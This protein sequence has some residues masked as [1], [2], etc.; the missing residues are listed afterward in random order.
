M[1]RDDHRRSANALDFVY[2]AAMQNHRTF[3]AHHLLRPARRIAVAISAFYALALPFAAVSA[4]AGEANRPAVTQPTTPAA[5]AAASPKAGAPGGGTRAATGSTGANTARRVAASQSARESTLSYEQVMYQYLLS[6]IA[7]QRG[8]GALATRGMLDLAKRSNDPRIARRAAEIAFQS[9]QMSE[10]REAL[11]LWLGL[12]P[13]AGVAR[14]ALAALV[15][16]QA[17]LDKTIEALS[18]WLAEKSFQPVLFT[19]TP[20]LVARFPDRASAAAAVASLASR[21]PASAEAQ[22]AVAATAQLAG[23]STKALDAIERA[24][25]LAPGYA[26]AAMAKADILRSQPDGLDAATDFLARFLKGH[27]TE[28]AVRS[29]Y[30]RLLVAGKSLLSAR[31]EFRRVAKELPRDPEPTYASG[32]ISLQM[33]DWALAT[34]AF[35]ETLDREPRD[36]NP[37]LFN[38]AMAA[39]GR[40]DAEAKLSWLRQVTRAGSGEL[41]VSAQ[42]KLASE[43]AR[44]EGVDAGR[45]FLRQAQAGLV[46]DEDEPIPAARRQIDVPDL[47]TQLIMAEAQLLR[48]ASA[49]ADAYQVLTNALAEQPESVALRY[50]RAMVAE[51]LNRLDDM[52]SDLRTV[53]SVKP[54]HAHA[55]NALGYTFAERGMRLDEAEALITRAVA[56][57]PEDPFILDSLGWVQ[58]KRGQL[59]DAEAT[60]VRAYGL[61]RD[62]EIAAHLAEVMWAAGRREAAL[63]FLERAQIEF[64]GNPTLSAVQARLRP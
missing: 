32:L 39:E 30:A 59:K 13:E 47:R 46:S 58:F 33:E 17:G 25:V 61:R 40:G 29:A 31:E 2:D 18:T 43:I 52:E 1:A 60:L 42:L 62:P 64:P 36:R 41:F 44:R 35:Q 48:D 5:P 63:A 23:D 4:E 22:Y 24:L 26:R 3:T 6:E 7:V 9:R 37:V 34:A 27:P 38:L 45:N 50:D 8:G 16:T 49:Y 28:T 14:Q 21:Y 53:M 57:A 12:E 20:Y 55:Y 15:G 54:D 10:A 19:Q 51:K 11:I 56:L